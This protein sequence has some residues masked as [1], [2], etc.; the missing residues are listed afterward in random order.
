MSFQ[1][2]TEK[3]DSVHLGDRHNIDK[4]KN[5]HEEVLV[6]LVYLSLY[7]HMFD[8]GLCGIEI[9]PRMHAACMADVR[10]SEGLCLVLDPR[11]MRN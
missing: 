11:E 5:S 9:G 2:R 1:F 3:K 7:T 4:D 10:S 8:F 6:V